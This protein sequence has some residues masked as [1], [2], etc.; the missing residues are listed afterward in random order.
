MASSSTAASNSAAHRVLVSD[1]LSEPGLALLKS[2]PSI[3]LD[4]QPGL[5]KDVTKLKAAIKDA[6]GLVIRSGT[7]VTKEIL[8][9]ARQLKVIG[10]AGIGVDNVDVD[11]ASRRGVIVMNTPG[12]NVITTAEHAISLM[13]ALARSIPQATASM[14]AGKWEKSKF[15]GSELSGKTLGL[16]GAG[17][18]GKIV[19]SRAQGLKMKVIAFD[20]FLTDELAEKLEVER[21]SLDELFARSDFITIHTPLN[22]KTRHLINKDAFAKMKKGVFIVNAARGGIVHELDLVAAIEQGIVAGAALD[23]FEQEPPPA[24]H[25][26]LREDRVI[27]TPHLGAATAEAQENV[28]VEVAEQFADFFQHDVIRNAVNF[29]SLSGKMREV[30]A[31]FQTLAEKLGSLHGQLAEEAPTELAIEYRGDITDYSLAT[32]T[33]RIVYGLLRPISEPDSVNP[34]NA[35][36]VAKDRGIQVIESKVREAGDYT[37]LIRV[38]VTFSKGKRLRIAGTVFGKSAI[39]LVSFDEVFLE[40]PLD[41]TIVVIHNE[42]RPGVIG[43]VGTCLGEHQVNISWMQLGCKKNGQAI[44]FYGVERDVEPDIVAALAK[45]PGLV[46]VQKVVL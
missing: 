2:C 30:L 27:S 9:A 34:V 12:G 11:E 22:D 17:N 28:A 37:N 38:S 29:P 23:V 35:I 45:T 19:A 21:V 43:R 24:D 13:C 14:K 7:T 15:M 8:E 46:S 32:L 41:G 16:I 20:P 44:S 40:A 26:L 18:I 25:P 10:R 4:Y 5:G 36:S 1:T 33:S 42:D 31:P 39:K 3:V 6:E